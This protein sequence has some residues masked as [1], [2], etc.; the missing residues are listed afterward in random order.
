MITVTVEN[1]ATFMLYQ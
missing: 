1:F